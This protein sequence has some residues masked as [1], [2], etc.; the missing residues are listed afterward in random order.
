[1]ASLR[2]RGYFDVLGAVAETLARAGYWGPAGV[3]SML[4]RDG[5]LV[6]VLEINA[7]R[8]LGL[9]A[10]S[11]DQRVREHGLRCH[12]WQLALTVPPGTGVDTLADVL[13]R[14]GIRYEGDARPGASLLSGS[15]LAAPGGRVHCALMC[16]PE[17]VTTMRRRLLGAVAAAGM[18]VRGVADA[19]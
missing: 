14:D 5:R 17:D 13:R 8:S 15:G 2:A 10:M 19:A 12:L 7:R 11:L 9:L 4:L 16:V 1:V 18:A 6:P 3:D